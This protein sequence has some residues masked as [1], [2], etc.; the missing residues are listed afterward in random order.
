MSKTR[1]TF[2]TDRCTCG[3]N[4]DQKALVEHYIGDKNRPAAIL[5]LR[6]SYQKYFELCRKSYK[7]SVIRELK[8][9][10]KKPYSVSLFEPQNWTKDLYLINTSLAERSGGAMKPNYLRTPEELKDAYRNEPRIKEAQ[11]K[12]HWREWR[13]IFCEDQEGIPET[14]V[15]Y[16]SLRR[17]GNAALYGLI[18]GHGDHLSN[19]IMYRLHFECC[20]R[21]MDKKRQSSQGLEFLMYGGFFDGKKGLLQWKKKLMFEPSVL[22]M[23]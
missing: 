11:C 1:I 17:V 3:T 9:T 20:E 14:L 15:G 7:K 16:I 12:H 4:D 6:R 18:L 19:G 23:K 2:L 8:K 22:V 10:F 5:D 13:G 21:L